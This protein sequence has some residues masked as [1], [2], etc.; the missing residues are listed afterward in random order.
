MRE[1][2]GHWAPSALCAFIS[3]VAL[4]AWA[5]SEARGESPAFFAF[6]PMCFVLVGVVTWRLRNE[7]RELRHRL[8]ALEARRPQ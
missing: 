6:L 8:Q 7:I 1:A 3:V 5:G 4:A 2:I